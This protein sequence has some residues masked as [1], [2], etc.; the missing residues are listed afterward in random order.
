MEAVPPLKRGLLSTERPLSKK[1]DIPE[2]SNKH[3][4][5]ISAACAAGCWVVETLCYPFTTVKVRLQ[6]NKEQFIPFF[7]AVKTYYKQ[8]GARTFYKGYSGTLPCCFIYNFIYFFLYEKCNLWQLQALSK[9]DLDEN[10]IDTAKRLLPFISG[11]VGEGLAMFIYVPFNIPKLRMQIDNPKYHYKGLCDGIAKV[12]KSEGLSKF[13]RTS[14]VQMTANVIYCGFLMSIYE[15]LRKNVLDKK[16]DKRMT[17][18]ET[19]SCTILTSLACSLTMSPFEVIIAHFVN[20]SSVKGHATIR[21]LI[22]ELL[23]HEGVRGFYKGLPGKVIYSLTHACV[24]MPTF[25]FLRTNYGV[26]LF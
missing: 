17:L 14:Q 15:N 3:T 21:G 24:Y 11:G 1:F 16:E 26:K 7:Q 8:E 10:Q 13:F 23:K 22:K 9:F 20:H 2:V 25:E 18:S 4:T 12:Y 19:L 5:F 6:T